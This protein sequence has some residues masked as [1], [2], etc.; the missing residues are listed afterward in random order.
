MHVTRPALASAVFLVVVIAGAV[1]AA[2]R[3]VTNE[4]WPA[5]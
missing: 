4:T 1:Y 3:A 5:W 2:V